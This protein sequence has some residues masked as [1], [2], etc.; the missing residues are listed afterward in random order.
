[1]PA[2]LRRRGPDPYAQ[3]YA[4]LAAAL[5]V[6]TVFLAVWLRSALVL[7]CGALAGA[8]ITGIVFAVRHFRDRGPEID[9]TARYL[10]SPRDVRSLTTAG[11]KE[12]AAR[13]GARTT[14][15]GIPIGTSVRGRQELWGSWE[16]MH[17][18]I[19]GPRTGKT[20]T[21]AIP[22]VVSAPGAVVVTSNKR[23]IVDATRGVR[24]RRG[25][26]WVFDPQNQ[27]NEPASWW[28]NPL[29]FINNN[30]VRAMI[31]AG[32]FA[33]INRPSHARSDGYFEPAG[34]ELF[35]AMLLAASADNL[36]ITRVLTWLRRP[37]DDTAARILRDAGHNLVAAS[38]ESVMTAPALQRAGVYGTAAQIASPLA[39]PNVT[40]WVTPGD[41]PRRP[42]F[43]HSDFAQREDGT[44]YVLS[45]ETNKM[46]APL[47]VSLATAL[48][49]EFEGRAI[50]S[51]GGRLP[52]P[53]VFVLDE[54]ANICPWPELPML[55]THYGSRGIIMMT[56][57]QSWAQGA[58]VWGESGMSSMWG[59]ANVRVYGGGSGDTRFL[60]DVSTVSPNFEAATNEISYTAFASLDQ[61]Q[62][63]KS[64]SE[65]VLDIAVLGAMPRGRAWVQVSGSKPILVRTSPWW[66]G[67]HAD[68]I[69]ASLARYG[70]DAP[71][72]PRAAK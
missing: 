9:R 55:Y 33:G 68:A 21:R 29:T 19:W 56:I 12:T 63:L 25:P 4:I 26:V 15:P 69:R 3:Q 39:A 5:L 45:E 67:A 52:V 70:P 48:A 66:E 47:V 61:K 65:E 44:V 35:G 34:Q 11:A 6:G 46:A 51:P 31:L 27:A 22:A 37:S 36:P 10:A 58:D 42:E 30:V 64:R 14:V 71:D 54:A 57:I 16:D 17:F 8:T 59:A 72:G 49:Y 53:A 28:W 23:D 32:L 13:L 43:R 50:E 18:D 62:T 7:L 60:G 24:E 2:T 1:M 40:R 38:V 41:G 20:A